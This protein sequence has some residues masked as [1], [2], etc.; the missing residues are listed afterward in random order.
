MDQ[1]RREDHLEF[2][3]KKVKGSKFERFITQTDIL[4]SNRVVFPTKAPWFEGLKKERSFPPKSLESLEEKL[5]ELR[6]RP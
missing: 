4:Q 1:L 5:A 3:P 6:Q 2:W